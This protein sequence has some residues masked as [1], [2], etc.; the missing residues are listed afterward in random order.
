MT[1]NQNIKEAIISYFHSGQLLQITS[2]NYGNLFFYFI[3]YKTAV[4]SG[5][6]FG[7]WICGCSLFYR[8]ELWASK[9]AV[10]KGDVPKVYKFVDPLHPV[11][12]SQVITHSFEG[13][14]YRQK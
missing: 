7:I 8:R 2:G 5:H 12:I 6:A 1:I 13:N 9:Y 10:A 14:N 4:S 3:N 11:W